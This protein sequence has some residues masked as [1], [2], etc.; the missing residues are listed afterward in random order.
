M[1]FALAVTQVTLDTLRQPFRDVL[2]STV[3]LITSLKFQSNVRI[4]VSAAKIIH[5]V[6]FAV[7]QHILASTTYVTPPVLRDISSVLKLRDAKAVPMIATLA[8]RTKPVPAAVT[9]IL[10]FIII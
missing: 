10:G 3:I 8:M 2:L 4:T 5:F 6:L 7:M 1:G 9:K